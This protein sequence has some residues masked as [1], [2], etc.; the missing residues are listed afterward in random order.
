MSLVRFL[1]APLKNPRRKSWVFLFPHIRLVS[2]VPPIAI[3]V[4]APLKIPHLTLWDF[5]FGSFFRFAPS[6]CSLGFGVQS[7][8]FRVRSSEFGVRLKNSP[9]PEGWPQ[10][11]VEFLSKM[12]CFFAWPL[13]FAVLGSRFGVRGSGFRVQSSEF[14]LKIPL[15]RRGGRRP[16]WAF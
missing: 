16:G 8:E 2:L 7:S 10:A 13:P 5:L 6:C 4:E 15:L 12:S 11:G 9:P 14:G 1:E 3:G